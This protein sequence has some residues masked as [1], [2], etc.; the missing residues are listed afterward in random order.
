MGISQIFLF[1]LPTKRFARIHPAK[2]QSKTLPKT[3]WA[4]ARSSAIGPKD[5]RRF[6]SIKFINEVFII[7]ICYSNPS[8]QYF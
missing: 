7:V 6:D 3:L 8:D 5:P 2:T 4:I 1:L